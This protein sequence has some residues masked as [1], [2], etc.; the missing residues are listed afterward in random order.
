MA[1]ETWLE[2]IESWS[3]AASEYFYGPAPAE[4]LRRA[5]ATIRSAILKL[6]RERKKTQGHES[7]LLS[8]TKAAAPNARTFADL[9]PSL[10]AVANARRSG[11]RIDAL[12]LKMRRLQQQLVETEVS[13]SLRLSFS[14]RCAQQKLT[15]TAF[16]FV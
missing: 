5:N 9:R 14:L 11:T 12:V 1:D 4:I 8:A 7:T 2:T 10:L 15:K 16:R 6:E 13:F 3:E